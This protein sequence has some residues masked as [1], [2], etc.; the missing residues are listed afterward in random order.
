MAAPI[1]QQYELLDRVICYANSMDFWNAYLEENP[2][3]TAKVVPL[4]IA[5]SELYVG[6]ESEK[7]IT[8]A[9]FAGKVPHAINA[10]LIFFLQHKSEISNDQSM[11]TFFR[12][13]K[14]IAIAQ[15][16]IRKAEV[17]TRK[18]F[19]LCCCFVQDKVQDFLMILANASTENITIPMVEALRSK[20][21]AIHGKLTELNGSAD[22][23]F[24]ALTAR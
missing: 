18:K 23:K 7:K 4:N 15:L 13:I 5:L 16:A 8:S 22:E 17:N 6:S 24:V 21:R 20:F 11:G 2:M 10:L 1:W 14:K 19:P 12:G 3:A 9:Q